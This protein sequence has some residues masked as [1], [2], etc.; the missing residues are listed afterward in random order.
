MT[1]LVMLRYLPLGALF[2][3]QNPSLCSSVFNKIKTDGKFGNCCWGENDAGVEVGHRCWINPYKRVVECV[4]DEPPAGTIFTYV[5][6]EGEVNFATS[7]LDGTV[8]LPPVRK[9]RVG[10]STARR[11]NQ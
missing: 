3:L 2:K 9:K 4:E 11:R 10:H 1:R 5:N 8:P 6:S 7:D